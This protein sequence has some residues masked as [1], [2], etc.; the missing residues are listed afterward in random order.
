[1]NLFECMLITK[2]QVIFR[3]LVLITTTIIFFINQAR[4]S[5]VHYALRK[6]AN[7]KLK[8]S[9]LRAVVVN[10]THASDDVTIWDK[11]AEIGIHAV[12]ITS[13]VAVFKAMS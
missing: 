6:L 11:V 5:W 3:A 9:V 10:T 12:H 4:Y 13:P 1:M 2:L 8:Y 7:L